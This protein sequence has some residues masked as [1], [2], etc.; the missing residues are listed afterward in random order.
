MLEAINLHKRYHQGEID[1]VAVD[2]FSYRFPAG[3]TAIVGPSGSGKTTLLNLLAGFD[4]PS[5]GEVRLDTTPLSTLSEDGRSEVRLK[6][7]G[8]V[9]QQWNLIPTLTALENVAFPMMLAGVGLKERTARAAHLL[10]AVGLGQRG[11]HLPSK[12][13]GGEQQR[14]AIARALALNPPILFADEP[15]GNLDSVSGAL[16]V[17]LLLQQAQEGRTV[18]LV[19]H[20]LELARKAER[21]LHLKDGRLLRVEEMAREATPPTAREPV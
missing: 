20:D 14:V 16:V 11:K 10:Q 1:V 5:E 19:T 12:L 8:F 18:V 6:H 15:T 17:D 3:L 4:V 21:I 7:M 2:H 13:S 9:F